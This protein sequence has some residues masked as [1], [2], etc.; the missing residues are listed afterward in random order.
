MDVRSVKEMKIQICG[1]SG[2]GKSTFAQ[3]LNQIYNIDLLFIDTIKF[4]P[5]WKEHSHEY[6]QN[7]ILDFMNKDSWIIDGNYFNDIPARFE[8]CDQLFFFKFNRFKCLY[9]AIKRYRLYKNT[10]RQ[11][12]AP[13]CKEKID[14]SFIMWILHGGRTKFYK[15]KYKSLIEKHKNKIIIFK[16]RRQ[17]NNYLKSIGYFLPIKYENK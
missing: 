10:T 14:L 17:V 16:N 5:N 1:F 15:Q 13:G 8:V 9:G 6:V 3:R 11:S 12:I 4:A 7:K 2:S